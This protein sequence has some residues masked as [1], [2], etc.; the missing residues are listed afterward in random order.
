MRPIIFLF[1]ILLTIVFFNVV[2]GDSETGKQFVSVSTFVF[3]IFAGF[4]IARQGRRYNEITRSL[5]NFD[6]NVSAL[7]RLIGYFGSEAERKM[8]DNIRAYYKPI[9]ENHAWDWNL[10]H[11][12]SLMSNTHAIVKEYGAKEKLTD[13][14]KSAATQCMVML[15]QLQSARKFLIALY[16]ERIP[17]EQWILIV[18]LAGIL[19][20]TISMLPSLGNVLASALKAAYATT[21][22][23]VIFMLRQ[24]DALSFYEGSIGE[25]S[26]QDVLDILAGK[27]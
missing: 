10:T 6:G 2:I 27:K 7:Y 22:L 25:H 13:L 11:K 26:A 19:L 23:I 3:A 1:P 8:S 18:S 4:F 12:S 24:F 17:R 20:V 16:Q 21:I 15:N 9:F 5:T 14:E